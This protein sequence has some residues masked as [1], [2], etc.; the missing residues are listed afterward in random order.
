LLTGASELDQLGDERRH[1]GQLLDDVGEQPLALRSREPPPA[2]EH[3]D[4]GA[5]AGQRR[6]QLVRRVGDELPLLASRILQRAEHRVEAHG[7]ATELVLAARV[8][9]LRE[10]TGLGHLLGGTC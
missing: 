1:L 6:A 8:D 2:R 3:L 5:Q 9:P 4:V 7:Q 10:V